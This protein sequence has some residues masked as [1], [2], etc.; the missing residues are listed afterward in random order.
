MPYPSSYTYED[1]KE[2]EYLALEDFLHVI[3]D[4]LWATFWHDDGPLPFSVSFPRCPG[5][6]F[7]T[8]EQV[9]PRARL[10]SVCGAAL[11]S[12]TGGDM[13]V[14]WDQ[15]V[16]FTLFK[17]DIVQE[18][19]IFSASTICEALFYGFRILLCRSLSKFKSAS[20]DSV[21]LL[22]LDPK[23][24]GVIKL[25]GDLRKLELNS[26][27][28]CNSVVEWIKVHAHVS[29]S[30]VERIW[31]KLGNPNW[32]D[33]GTLQL[34]L[35]TFYSI[36]QWTGPPRKSISKLAGDHS[37]RL[38]KRRM[39]MMP[40]TIEHW[41]QTREI[42]EADHEKSL[43]KSCLKLKRGEIL[44]LEDKHEQKGY[45]IQDVTGEGNC[46]SYIAVSVENPNELLAVYVGSHPSILEPSWE[47][48][49][50]WYH[51]QRQT[52]VLNM[53]KQEGISN[54][55]LPEIVFS[56]RILHSG[57]CRKQ[58]PGGRCDHPWCGTPVLVT[59]PVGEPLSSLVARKGAL[60][61]E[62]AIRCCRDCLAALRSAS[63]A[64]IQ[65]GDI[66]PQN[67]VCVS[68]GGR[69]QRYVP[70]SWGRAVIEDK[71]SPAVNL[72]FSSTHALQLGKL[73]PASDAESLVYVLY[74][75]CGGAMH[76]Q[77]QDSI[78][79]ALLWR[80]NCWADR[81]IQ[82]Q[83]GEVSALLKAFS[84]Y[85]D[86]LCGTPYAVGYDIWL[87]RLD[88]AVDGSCSGLPF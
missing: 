13:H 79:S 21:Y 5:F 27:N 16:Q 77:Q 55:H 74:F 71:D 44:V 34:L 8:V 51:V 53:L 31:N 3:A 54:N 23:F 49:S 32:G 28:P 39:E 46:L 68:N 85:V 75:V 57:I 41:K 88:A 56:G 67:I 80:E 61:S 70:V 62:E 20:G 40:P 7:Y 50:L 37:L 60:S 26:V 86:S 11:V 33:L 47:G 15:V 4:G 83:L 76:M 30:P 6:K 59:R 69:S 64:N 65:H 73:C 14:Q 78:E 38:E 72:Q 10:R 58:S 18:N 2:D 84:D 87:K 22:I 12:K 66:C 9:M 43:G 63:M 1:L 45:L 19:N 36:V 25:R 52:K 81:Y 82:Q 17:E 29:I 48:M 42:V 35:A 24:G